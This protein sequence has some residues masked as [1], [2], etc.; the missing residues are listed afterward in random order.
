VESSGEAWASLEN[1]PGGFDLIVLDATLAGM[2]LDEMA[3][4]MLGAHPDLRVLAS[5]GYPVDTSAIE[6]AVPGRIMFLHKP[7]TP[8]ALG[9][10]VRRMLAHKEEGI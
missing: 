1:D 9:A 8:E 2:S 6:S 10:L 7:F 4:R 5:S 3:L